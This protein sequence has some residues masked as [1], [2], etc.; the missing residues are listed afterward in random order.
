MTRFFKGTRDAYLNKI[1]MP[2]LN[3][4][5][6]RTAA[7]KILIE[8]TQRIYVAAVGKLSKPGLDK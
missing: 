1:K 8:N 4:L 7:M 3:A 5:L 2:F 6:N